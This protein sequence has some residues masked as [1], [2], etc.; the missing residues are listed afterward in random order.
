MCS[1]KINIPACS[2]YMRYF[3]KKGYLLEAHVRK[4]RL[5]KRTH[6]GLERAWTLVFGQQETGGTFDRILVD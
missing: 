6:P 3:R 5:E 4:N 1:F 2:S